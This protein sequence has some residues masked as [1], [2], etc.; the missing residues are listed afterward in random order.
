M[1]RAAFSL[2]NDRIAPVF[3]VARNL[4]IV[5]AADGA[6]TARIERRFSGD[7]PHERALRLMSLQVEQVI[8]GAITREIDCALKDRGI[9]VISFV[10]GDL[11]QVIEAWLQGRLHEQHLH[12]P[13]CGRKTTQGK[14][15]GGGRRTSEQ[16]HDDA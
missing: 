13:G 9:K 16:H 3:D 8:C 1:T 5:D 4:L 14:G 7:S 10:S 12:M 6:V 2:W 11:E 15:F